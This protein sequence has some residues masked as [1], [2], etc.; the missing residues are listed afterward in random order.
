MNWLDV[1]LLILLAG[2][3]ASSLR[4]GLT[5][6]LIGFASVVLAL[7]LGTWF[8]GMA[9]AFLLPYVSSPWVA[10]F[11]GFVLVFVAV[12]MLGGLVSA[13]LGK[14]LKITG[15]SIVDHLMGAGFGFLRGMVAAVALVMALMAFAPG[16]KPPAAVADSH[17]APYV[18]DAARIAATVAPHE[19]REGVRKSYQQLETVWA[20]TWK[21]GI[22]ELPDQNKAQGR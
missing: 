2:S 6:E 9:G 12:V 8:Y 1:V 18:V 16:G 19:L 11:A 20:N 21:Q 14:V 7:V 10:K 3:V 15:L 13:I 5:R 17:L 22:R 4:K